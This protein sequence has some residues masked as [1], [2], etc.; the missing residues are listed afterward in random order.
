MNKLEQV[1]PNIG[2]VVVRWVEVIVEDNNRAYHPHQDWVA[3]V[4]IGDEQSVL[5]WG[6]KCERF[7]SGDK[8]TPV[9]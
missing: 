4:R 5:V 9:L 6:L 8:W 7:K 3:M 1:I 2:E